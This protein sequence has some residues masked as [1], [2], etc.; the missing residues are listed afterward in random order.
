MLLHRTSVHGYSIDNTDRTSYR[1]A[2]PNYAPVGQ[3][4]NRVHKPVQ[5]DTNIVNNKE[6]IPIVALYD[7]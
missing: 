3:R 6:E 5:S 1:I 4:D 2:M 7:K